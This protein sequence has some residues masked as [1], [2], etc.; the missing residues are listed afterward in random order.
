LITIVFLIIILPTKHDIIFLLLSWLFLIMTSH[1]AYY[2]TAASAAAS[3]PR[4]ATTQPIVT[5]TSVLGVIYDGGVMLAA[6]TRLSYGGMAKF[7]DARRLVAI[8]NNVLIGG[9]GEYSDFTEI[10]HMLDE[11]RRLDQCTGDSLYP[12]HEPTL[13]AEQTWNYLRVIMYNRRNKMNPLWNDIVIAGY[14]TQKHE[15]FLGWVD[16]IGTTVSDKMIATGFGGYLALPLMREKWTPHMTE[17]EARALLEDGMRVLFY[18]D[19]RASP[20]IQLAK[21]T[22]PTADGESSSTLLISEPYELE[23]TWDLPSMINPRAH[24]DGGW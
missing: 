19:C 23:T 12:D 22:P 8:G 13:N 10:I 11:K 9:G 21:I 3:G 14:T 18:R 4:H 2:T 7:E 20:K 15:P 24:V 1:P 5:G 17:G 16:K 6:D